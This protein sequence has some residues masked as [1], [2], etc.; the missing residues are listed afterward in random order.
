MTTLQGHLTDAQAQRLVDGA[1]PQHEAVLAEAH[2][3]GCPA[4]AAEVETYRLLSSALDDL[5]VPTLPADFTEGVLARID[6]E[7]R[8]LARERRHALAILAGVVAA[9]AAA[10]TVAGAAAWAPTLSSAADLFGTGARALQLASGFVPKIVSA[11]RFQ[12]IFAAAALAL[13]LLLALVRLMPAPQRVET[14]V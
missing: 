7:E 10:F 12:I 2:V 13:P 14:I 8:A 6:A 1:L 3:A 5:E 4:C 11:L 9:T